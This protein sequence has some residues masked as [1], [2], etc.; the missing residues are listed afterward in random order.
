M[1]HKDDV[2]SMSFCFPNIVA[3]SSYDGLIVLTNIQS[4][5][6]LHTLD[7]FEY[8]TVSKTPSSIDK[9]IFSIFKSS[10]ISQQ[11]SS[12]KK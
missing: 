5:H 4:G 12:T 6:V 10:F 2:L 11:S 1:W 9:G 7:P 8:E 3:T